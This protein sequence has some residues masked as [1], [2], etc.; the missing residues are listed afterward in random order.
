MAR[1]VE[2][3]AVPREL[4]D[5]AEGPEAVALLDK[6]IA[7]TGCE[8]IRLSQVR[9]G[10]C[11]F[12]VSASGPDAARA[13]RALLDMH[14]GFQVELQQRK[15]QT[16]RLEQ[17]LLAT[18]QEFE[19]GKRLEFSVPEKLIGLVIGKQGANLTKVKEL[20]GVDKIV[21]DTKTRSVRI[22]GEDPEAVQRA[23]AMLEYQEV[24]IPVPAAQ[25]RAIQGEKGRN[26]VEMWKKS[27]CVSVALDETAP[28]GEGAGAGERT[29]RIVG[30]KK[31]VDLAR[32]MIETQLEFEKKMQTLIKDESQI[33]KQLSRIDS[34]FREYGPGGVSSTQ[35][36]NFY[37]GYQGSGRTR[38][39]ESEGVEAG[40]GSSGANAGAGAKPRE[41]RK[42]AS[43]KLGPAAAKLPPPPQEQSQPQQQQQR[44]ARP[45][46]AKKPAAVPA[47]QDE[48]EAAKRVV[49]AQPKPPAAAPPKPN[50]AASPMPAAAATPKPT[51]AA[52]APPKKTAAKTAAT[53]PDAA[54][55]DEATAATKPAAAAPVAAPQASNTESGAQKKSGRG[56]RPAP[57]SAA[58]PAATPTSV[59]NAAPAAAPSATPAAPDAAA[60]PPANKAKPNGEAKKGGRGPKPA[61]APTAAAAAPPAAP[62][63]PAAPEANKTAAPPTDNKAKPRSQKNQQQSAPKPKPTKP[64]KPA[65]P[66]AA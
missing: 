41:D 10:K 36:P 7:K 2:S 64:A 50:A 46:S 45:P 24:A 58:A 21:V 49:A 4:F 30:I 38:R 18:T 47:A 66:A 63:A 52:A 20:T 9:P 44:G 33:K 3:V 8:A 51:A 61:T 12:D 60:A 32:D 31:A 35:A 5:W 42:Q 6:V 34:E 62:A 28:E 27:G 22:R 17:D 65:K 14:L 54:A 16:E 26:L 57:A 37:N 29:V 53:K 48:A 55:A 39:R 1:L 59:P 13:A 25:V 11:N 15:Q 23:R 40:S 43:P 19:S 56:P